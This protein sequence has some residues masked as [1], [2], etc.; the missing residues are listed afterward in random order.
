MSLSKVVKQQIS[1]SQKNICAGVRNYDCPMKGSCWDES[2]YDVDHIVEFSLTKCNDPNN[3]QAL[4]KSCHSTKT[5]RYMSSPIAKL[6][7]NAKVLH[8]ISQYEYI[9]LVPTSSL[10]IIQNWKGNRP[11]DE[12]RV[13]NI[14]GT[15]NDGSYVENMLYVAEI[16]DY[17]YIF[18]YD[19]NHR[20]EALRMFE[21]KDK[22]ITVNIIVRATDDIVS[23]RFIILNQSNPVPEVYFPESDEKNREGIEECVFELQKRWPT[24]FSSSSRPRRPNTNR[25][26]LIQRIFETNNGK[27]Y[28]KELLFEKLLECNE[29]YKNGHH[30]N[31]SKYSESILKK[32]DSTGCFLFLKDFTEDLI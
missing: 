9:A 17:G 3:L 23:K 16:G 1:E 5:K 19:G 2:G 10:D 13:A 15:L 6:M 14:L 4:C 24:H 12:S 7:R 29:N 8:A 18:C 31:L 28:N 21:C 25:D 32:C 20:L 27:K 30:I 26:I 11:P 22:M